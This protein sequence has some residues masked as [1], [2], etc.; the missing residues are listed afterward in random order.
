MN[1]IGGEHI[2]RHIALID[3]HMRPLTT[4]CL[5][6]SGSIGKFHLQSI[7]IAV[8]L[9]LFQSVLFLGDISII[10][11]HCLIELFLLLARQG[12]SLGSQCVEHHQCCEFIVVIVRESHCHFG[13]METIL[14]M[15]I[16]HLSD[17]ATVSIGYKLHCRH[18]TPLTFIVPLAYRRG[19]RGEA[20]II[21]HHHQLVAPGESFLTSQYHIADALIIDVCTFITACN[22]HRFIKSYPRI[23]TCQRLYQ[24]VTGYHSDILETVESNLRQLTSAFRHPIPDVCRIPQN[25]RFLTLSQNLLKVTFIDMKTIT[26]QHIRHQ[27]RTLLF[28]YWGQLGLVAYQQHTTISSI[29]HKLNQIV[30]QLSI[31]KRRIT[32]IAGIGN[33]RGLINYI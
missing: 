29:I 8:F 11:H 31:G 26:S 32:I 33:H 2:V 13:K 25:T 4:L 14:F 15:H 10:L 22:N 21:L 17:H 28:A 12:G 1:I 27:R 6:T 24:L 18:N 9:H 3:I 16:S 23:A 7:I 5:V 30:Q 19:V 20:I